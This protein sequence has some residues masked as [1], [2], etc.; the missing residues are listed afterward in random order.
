MI[1]IICNYLLSILKKMINKF[2]SQTIIFISI[3]YM[4]ILSFVSAA[5]TPF[6]YD[7]WWS[8][9]SKDPSSILKSTVAGSNSIWS[10]IMKAFF[11]DGLVNKSWNAMEYIRSLINIAISLVWFIALSM[12]IYGFFMIFFSKEEEWLKIAKSIVKWSVTAI[13]LI[14]LSWTIVS[15]MFWWVSLLRGA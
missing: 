15:L 6:P 2:K 9:S 14:W 3:I 8:T 7:N 5:P 10:Q 4:S 12:M 11:G 13:I 1:I